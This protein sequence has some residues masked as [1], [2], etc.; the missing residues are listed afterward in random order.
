MAKPTASFPSFPRINF[1]AAVALQ[2]ANVE[3]IVQVQKILADAAQATWQLQVK[4]IDAWKAQVQGAFKAFD[5]AKKPEAYAKDAQVAVEGAIADA[6]N[7]VERGV[8]VHNQVA[9]LLTNRM[10]ANMNE[11]KAL[12][13]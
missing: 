1:D 13:A 3:A 2:K 9:E 11:L 4:R 6:K 5:P 10:V 12:A 8:K 7:A